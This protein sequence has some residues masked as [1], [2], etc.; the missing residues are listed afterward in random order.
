LESGII[1]FG[2]IDYTILPLEKIGEGMDLFASA[3]DPVIKMT[4]V[5]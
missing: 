2:K 4:I 3:R 5:L 1:D